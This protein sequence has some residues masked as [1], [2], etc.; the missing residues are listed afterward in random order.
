MLSIHSKSMARHHF[1]PFQSSGVLYPFKA[2]LFRYQCYN[3]HV[4]RLSHVSGTGVTCISFATVYI[5]SQASWGPLMLKVMMKTSPY[6]RLLLCIRINSFFFLLRAVCFLNVTISSTFKSTMSFG[7]FL[8]LS[9]S[10]LFTTLCRFPSSIPT[11]PHIYRYSS[12]VISFCSPGL[13]LLFVLCHCSFPF[14][15][16]FLSVSCSTLLDHCREWFLSQCQNG[17]LYSL[18]NYL[19]VVSRWPGLTS[20]LLDFIPCSFFVSVWSRINRIIWLLLLSFEIAFTMSFRFY[21]VYSSTDPHMN[22][23]PSR[24]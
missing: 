12:V 22:A 1:H 13:V 20:Q 3:V 24:A 14:Y 2:D 15:C 18:L 11:R 10:P 21:V 19:H 6:I 9:R 16:S 7:S 23:I 8:Q 17:V 4:F 5:A